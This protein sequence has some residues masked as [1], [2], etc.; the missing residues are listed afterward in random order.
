M[1]YYL[2]PTGV[3]VLEEGLASY[4]P[5]GIIRRLPKKT[6]IKAEAEKTA[7]V[8]KRGAKQRAKEK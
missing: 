6:R 5:S 3:K 4:L 1:K 7:R 8:F 2:T